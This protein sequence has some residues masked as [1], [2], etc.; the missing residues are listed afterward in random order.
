MILIAGQTAHAVLIAD[1][2]S[3]SISTEIAGVWSLHS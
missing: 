2:W 1:M 3:D